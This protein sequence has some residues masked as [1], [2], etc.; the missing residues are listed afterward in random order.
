MDAHLAGLHDKFARGGK[1][2]FTVWKAA[3]MTLVRFRAGVAG[4]RAAGAQAKREQ[5]AGKA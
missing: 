2:D 1:D 5:G 3:R 4:G